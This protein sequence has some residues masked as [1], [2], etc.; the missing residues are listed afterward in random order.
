[1]P[2]IMIC[3]GMTQFATTEAGVRV[4]APIVMPGVGTSHDAGTGV[5]DSVTFPMATV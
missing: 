4:R 2:E 1:M 5:G 3:A